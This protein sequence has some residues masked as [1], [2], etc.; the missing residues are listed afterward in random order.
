M[1]T[2]RTLAIAAVGLALIAACAEVDDRTG[3]DST[4]GSGDVRTVE[5][6]MV[7]I[8]FEPDTLQVGRGET[9]RFVFSNRGE[10]A[11]D[12]FIGDAAAQAE[13]EDEM[14]QA[15]SEEGH[16]EG[17]GDDSDDAITIDPGDNAE[18]TYTFQQSGNV[19]IGCHQPG[20]YDAG[21]RIDVE[22]A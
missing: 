16:G 15:D 10:V 21:M 7:D 13:H 14:R 5:I 8:A 3:A 22:V 4:G 11:H 9:V 20:H 12:A 1:N 17:H 19:E 2:P 18:L 6:D